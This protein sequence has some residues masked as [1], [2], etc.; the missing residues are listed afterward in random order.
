[1]KRIYVAGAYS[2]NNVVSVLHNIRK[3]IEASY[4]VLT[5]GYAPFCPWLDYQY[6][7]FDSG[8]HLKLEDF[9]DYSIAWLDVSDAMLV[10]PGFENSNGTLKEIVYAEMNNIPIFYDIDDICLNV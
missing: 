9:Y 6:V 7:L 8:E 3:G 1:M 2:S 10:L 5:M 4:K